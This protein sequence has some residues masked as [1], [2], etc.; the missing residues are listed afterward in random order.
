MTRLPAIAS[1]LGFSLVLA[2][3]GNGSPDGVPSSTGKPAASLTTTATPQVNPTSAE[4][5]THS[6]PIS[7]T[8]SA[9][10]I[11]TAFNGDFVD[12]TGFT[13]S[14]S[15]LTA[16][17]TAAQGD[18]SQDAPGQY[19]VNYTLNVAGSITNTTAQ[20]R[21][22]TDG[23]VFNIYPIYA[24]SSLA[25]SDS[26]PDW[27]LSFSGGP[28][29]AVPYCALQGQGT[30]EATLP[31]YFGELELQGNGLLGGVTVSLT[32]NTGQLLE[33]D[34]STP[35]APVTQ[36]ISATTTDI[37]GYISSVNHPVGWLLSYNSGAS[38]A[39]KISAHN[40]SVCYSGFSTVLM[41]GC[42]PAS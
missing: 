13:Y 33:N 28:A 42:A 5:L 11:I 2:A 12:N 29:G 40:I 25:C 27:V 23:V 41:P 7:T 6:S 34:G 16:K 8:T 17:I 38:H 9:A 24:E 4:S 3:C 32:Q 14:L 30:N 36:S 21:T 39:A 37:G 15:H 20:N 18:S 1:I 22:L 26:A 10:K 19:Q 35:Q 31:S